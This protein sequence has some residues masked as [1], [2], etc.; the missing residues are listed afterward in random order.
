MPYNH[1]IMSFS[2]FVAILI[3][4]TFRSG[5]KF[6]VPSCIRSARNLGLET[7]NP[8]TALKKIPH[9]LLFN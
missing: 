8:C 9:S 3:L 6:Q 7:W 1:N 4:L 2:D 5:L